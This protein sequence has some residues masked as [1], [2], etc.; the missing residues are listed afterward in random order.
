MKAAIHL[1]ENSNDNLVTFRNTNFEALKTLFDI[2]QKLILNQK[3]DIKHVFTIEWQFTPWMRSTL[4]HDRVIKLSKAKVG[5][6]GATVKR[7][8]QIKYFQESKKYWEQLFGI[9]GEP[10]WV[11]VEYSPRTHYSAD[12]PGGSGK[13]DS[14][15]NK[16]WRIW[17]SDHSHVYVQRQRLD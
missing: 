9:D 11:R 16:T 1:G 13:N 7:K 15:Q 3:H 2:T 6:P 4:L 14:S 12:P 10:F 8:E 5:H 17:R